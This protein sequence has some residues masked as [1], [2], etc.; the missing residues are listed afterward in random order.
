MPSRDTD[1]L[2]GFSFSL[3]VQGTLQGYFTEIGGLGSETEIV[4]HK[5][6]DPQG[7]D[8]IQKIPGRLKFTDVTLKR[9]V[10]SLKD[11]WDWRKMVEDGNIVGARKNATITM[12]DQSL[13]AVARWNLT[14]AWPT[15]VSGP[16][17]QSDSNAFGVE[18]VSITFE[19]LIREI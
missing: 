10:T 6:V 12:Y 3:D 16:S 13:N 15:K 8:L 7:R 19:M 11:I 2:I 14:N 17:I 5:V 4:E 9:G 1:P 18:E